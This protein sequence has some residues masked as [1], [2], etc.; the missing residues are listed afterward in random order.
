MSPYIF[1]SD[2]E[3]TPDVL[4]AVARLPEGATFIYRHFGADNAFEMASALR[5]V[6]F[7]RGIQFLIG[8]DEALARRVGADGLHLPERDL[9]KGSVLRQ[10]YPDWVLSGAVHH[11]RNLENIHDLDGIIV[12]PVFESASASAGELIGI[13]GLQKIIQST[14]CPVFALGGVNAQTVGSLIG[15]GVAGIAG[16]SGMYHA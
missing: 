6:C 1:M 10:R 9:A 5:Q 13:M 12:S 14:P 15:V 8:Q 16:V 4:R 3:R 7:V 2:P 11:R